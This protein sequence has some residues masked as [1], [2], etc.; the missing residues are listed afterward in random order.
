MI[1]FKYEIA[2]I[3]NNALLK[4]DNN[5]KIEGLQEFIETPPNSDMGDYAF[6]CFRL[7]KDLRKAPQAIAADL[8]KVILE[9]L[10][11]NIIE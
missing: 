8:E 11:N 9:D 1:D 6:P 4:Q 7:A 2:N 5:L 3:I 10:N